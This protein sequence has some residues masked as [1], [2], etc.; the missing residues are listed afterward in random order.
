MQRSL[1]AALLLTVLVSGCQG[2]T[3]QREYSYKWGRVGP[4]FLHDFIKP[5][6]VSVLGNLADY[7][8]SDK[9]VTTAIRRAGERAQSIGA[10]TKIDEDIFLV[11]SDKDFVGYTVSIHSGDVDVREGLREGIKPTLVFPLT[12]KEALELPDII[13]SRSQDAQGRVVTGVTADNLFKLVKLMLIPGLRA[14][15]SIDAL[16]QTGDRENLGLDDLVQLEVVPPTGNDSAPARVTIINTDG[17]WLFLE[18]WHGDPDIRIRVTV[19]QALEIYQ[20]AVYSF[21]KAKTAT[22]KALA[23]RKFEE[24]QRNAVVYT[25]PDHK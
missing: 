18:G 12:R 24:L 15:Y 19:P 16:Y 9:D 20:A 2:L 22:D 4:R 1:V 17:Q 6:P 8:N 21:K 3:G 10:I 5:D 14:V 23:S 25:R 7:N 13:G 11:L